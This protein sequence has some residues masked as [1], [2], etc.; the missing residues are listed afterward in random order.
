MSGEKDTELN[1]LQILF[2]IKKKLGLIR[3]G[4]LYYEDILFDSCFNTGFNSPVCF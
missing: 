4:C 1:I 3:L 2:E